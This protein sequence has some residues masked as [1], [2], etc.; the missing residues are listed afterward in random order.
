MGLKIQTSEEI[1][2]LRLLSYENIWKISAKDQQFQA[3]GE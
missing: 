3:C 1:S 2:L